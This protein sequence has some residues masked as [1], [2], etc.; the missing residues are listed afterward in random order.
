MTCK[1]CGGNMKR[2]NLQT[3]DREQKTELVCENCGNIV[4]VYTKKPERFMFKADK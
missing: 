2:N 1:K 4:E 3:M